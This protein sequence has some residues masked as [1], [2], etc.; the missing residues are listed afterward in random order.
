MIKIADNL[1]KLASK[2]K[3]DDIA[4]ASPDYPGHVIADY[5]YGVPGTM[6]LAGHANLRSNALQTLAEAA[7]YPSE[8]ISWT[9]K[10]PMLSA[11]TGILGGGAIGG[12]IAAGV[13]A[14]R[15]ERMSPLVTGTGAVGGA[16]LGGLLTTLNRR[17]SIKDIAAKFDEAE[18]L[19]KLE[20]KNLKPL[21][22]IYEAFTSPVHPSLRDNTINEINALLKSKK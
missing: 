18:E 12:G 10:Y 8:N 9:L 11:L 14:L 20:P 7:D 2:V 17:K 4:F 1:V 21:D 19:K 5:L 15:G 3:A 22:A 6:L 13:D 16:L